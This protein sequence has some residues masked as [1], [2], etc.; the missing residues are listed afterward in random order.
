M[1]AEIH[2]NEPFGYEIFQTV[3]EF[4][5]RNNLEIGSWDGEGSSSCFVKAMDFLAGEKLLTCIEIIDEKF[6]I[7][8]QRFKN[9][10]FVR[11]FKGSSISYDSLI[12][13]DFDELWNSQFNHIP[14]TLYSKELV[15]SWY[16]RDIETIKKSSSF[17]EQNNIIYDS[18]LIDG[19]EF[20]GYS[21]Y[22]LIKNKCRVLFLDDVH[23]AYKCNQI[24]NELKQDVSWTLLTERP[25]VR[26][27]F[28]FFIKN[29][30]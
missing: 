25:D 28:A 18:I 8:E 12:P 14:K 3:I 10:S 5:L 20:T 9:K 1:N 17:L 7:L 19:G 6:N 13:K 23:H 26:N 27:G 16:D 22:S 24:Y 11:P 15:K 2:L 30:L 29:E 4:D 21:E